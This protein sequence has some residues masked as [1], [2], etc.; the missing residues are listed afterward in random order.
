M[1]KALAFL[2]T[3]ILAVTPVLAMASAAYTPGTYEGTAKGFGGT[4]TVTVTVDESAI[5]AVEATG[6]DETPAIGGAAL[7]TVAQAIVDAQGT[8]VDA[9]AGA[10]ITSNAVLQAA[11]AALAQARGEEKTASVV[12][13]GVYTASATSYN[14]TGV[15]LDTVT[16]TAAFEDGKL[17]SVEVGEYSDTPA[18]GGMAFD[19]LAQEVVAQQSL[20]IDSVA[21]ATVSSAGFFTAMADIVAQ[22][23]G[24]VAEWQSR[25]VEKRDPVTEEYEADVVVIGAG[26]AGLSATLEAASLGADVILVEKMEVLGSS[27]TRSEGYV[28]AAGTELQRENGVEDNVEALYEDI[29]S[30]YK[31]E[32]EVDGELIKQA[33]YDSTDYIQFLLDAGR[34]L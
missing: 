30:L 27:T 4:V 8:G 17:T 9:V 20:G 18:I 10:T 24:D 1:K 5:T 23:G 22:A 14:R 16:L 7:A 34:N 15:G 29:Y 3:V 6:G 19:L 2:L 21:G 28:Q 13:D 31:D 32:P 25:P 12:A 26:I 33:A 11:D